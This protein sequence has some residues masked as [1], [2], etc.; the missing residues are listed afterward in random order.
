ML[1]PVQQDPTTSL[2]K[3]SNVHDRFQEYEKANSD[4]TKKLKSA[5]L[6][7]EQT[8]N[9]H[10]RLAADFQTKL[11]ELKV[12]LGAKR[13][14]EKELRGKERGYLI[15]IQTVRRRIPLS[16]SIVKVLIYLYIQCVVV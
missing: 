15:Q 16:Q 12:D 5:Q 9:D 13:R 10:E 8:A 14:E 1:D 11:E 4:L 6:E 7:L 2:F 3:L